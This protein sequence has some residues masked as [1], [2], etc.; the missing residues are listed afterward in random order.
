MVTSIKILIMKRIDDQ[1]GNKQHQKRKP[2]NCHSQIATM[3]SVPVPDLLAQVL[4]E[5]TRVYKNKT[6][7]EITFK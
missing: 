5:S 2:N 4:K 1:L 3:M 6:S 7:A